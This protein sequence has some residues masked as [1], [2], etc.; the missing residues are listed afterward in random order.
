MMREKR[1]RTTLQ[2]PLPHLGWW[3]GLRG[4]AGGWSGYLY[5]RSVIGQ[6]N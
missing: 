4:W 1:L 5:I 3:S 2:R 6:P